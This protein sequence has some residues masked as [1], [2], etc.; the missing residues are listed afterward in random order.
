M[1]LIYQ[2]PHTGLSVDVQTEHGESGR[3]MMSGSFES[4]K[5]LYE[6]APKHVPKPLAWGH[7]QADEEMWFFLSEFREM[8]EDTVDVRDLV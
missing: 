5:L 3:R 6:Y 7:Y 8:V 2:P 4:E 1:E